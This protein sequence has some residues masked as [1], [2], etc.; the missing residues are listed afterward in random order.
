MLEERSREEVAAELGV[1]LAT[2]DVVLHRALTAMRK[3]VGPA[4]EGDDD[5]SVAKV[6]PLRAERRTS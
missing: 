1:T 3:A 4:D 6:T 2:F 5:R